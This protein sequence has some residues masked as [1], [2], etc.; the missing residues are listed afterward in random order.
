ME[1][2]L[3]QKEA[4]KKWINDGAKL[5]DVQKLLS[6]KFNVK[7]TYMDVRFLVDDLDLT[8]CD[9]KSENLEEPAKPEATETETPAQQGVTVEVNPVQRPGVLTG[10][11]VT[12]S[13]GVQATW[14]LDVDGRLHLG[15]AADDYR[16]SQEDILD[17]QQKLR[18]ILSG[19]M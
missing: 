7:M 8:M 17:F 5:V 16:P 9:P 11:N 1:L 15:G 3:E 10:G 14:E 4:V 2:S 6:E 12:F 19:A 13:D 18:T